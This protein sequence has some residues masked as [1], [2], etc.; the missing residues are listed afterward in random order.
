MSPHSALQL[1]EEATHVVRSAPPRALLTYYAGAVPFVVGFLYFSADMSTSPFAA[2]HAAEAAL[3]VTALFIWMKVCQAAF[4]QCI[5]AEVAGRP[6]PSWSLRK[7]AR[8]AV[9]QTA[10]QSTGLFLTPVAFITAVP[11]AW[12]YAFY[13]A[14]AVLD[15][16]RSEISMLVR[17]AWRQAALWPG[18]N[19][20]VLG[21]VL[22]FGLCVFLNWAALFLTVPFLVKMLFG[23]ESMFTRSPLSALSTTFLGATLGLT[24]LT[25]DP[26]VKAVYALRSFYGESLKSGEDLTAALKAAAAA[27]GWRTAAIVAA[28]LLACASAANAQ[29]S[30]SAPEAAQ[31]AQA[32]SAAELD[33]RIDDV[34]HQPKYAW[35][36]PRNL[37][38]SESEKGVI[39]RFLDS[40]GSLV[41]KGFRAILNSL[42]GW[43]DRWLRT[44]PSGNAGAPARLA[45]RLL[46]Y[47]LLAAVI[48]S[49]ALFFV[50]A[51]RRRTPPAAPI[52]AEAVSGAPDVADENIGA[53]TLP[54]DG[55]IQVAR[56]L[57]ERGEF[58]LAMRAF[59]FAALAHL[60]RRNLIVIAK[61]KSNR[62]YEIELRRRAH[63]L[64]DLLMFFQQ[65]VSTF[66]R[67][68]YGMHEAGPEAVHQFAAGVERIMGFE[69]AES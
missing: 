32:V 39:G 51:R 47:A 34:I 5:L 25:V 41:K 17:R 26:I 35:R 57:L 50:R 65:T 59:H 18:Q 27:P 48:G 38:Q 30:S 55:W 1:I 8:V 60:A 63:T 53:E 69:R 12:A 23:I 43:I 16:G 67:F 66:E 61:F 2:Q 20:L 24:Y 28:I 13:Q 6:A 44:S 36:L 22:A 68:W 7:A 58:R 11:L 15:D 37:E 64:P 56:G 3:G 14:A 62:D 10:I 54:E 49:I 21:A 46:L 31:A 42:D 52:R 9:S 19:H 45:A 4:A 33:R 40:V 29:P